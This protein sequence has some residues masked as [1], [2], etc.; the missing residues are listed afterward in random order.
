VG[1][2]SCSLVISISSQPAEAPSP[3]QGGRT[4]AP[5]EQ[6]MTRS[7]G[8]ALRG[9]WLWEGCSGYLYYAGNY[10]SRMCLTLSQSQG[11]VTVSLTLLSAIL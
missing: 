7:L 5:P 8:T 6:P 4:S 9:S 10:Y 3:R 2:H 11:G 1:F